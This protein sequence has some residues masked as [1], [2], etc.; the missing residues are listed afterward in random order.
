MGP[1]QVVARLLEF[2]RLRHVHPLVLAR[3][4]TAG[5]PLGVLLLFVGGPAMAPLFGLLHGAGNGMLTLT[6]G[7]LPL[8]LFG[9]AGYGA[10]QG[11]LMAPARLLQASAPFVTGLV[12]ERLGALTLGL[13]AALGVAAW[14]ALLQVQASTTPQAGPYASRDRSH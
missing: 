10:R 11:L 14:I 4:A 5:H 8:A 13:T 1:A 12:I 3:W 9:S 7:S 2:T 6:K